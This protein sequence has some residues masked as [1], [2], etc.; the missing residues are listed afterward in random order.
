MFEVLVAMLAVFVAMLAALVLTCVPTA[1]SCEP[2]TASVLFCAIVPA[3]TFW[4]W[5]SLPAE[6]TL[7][8]PFVS[9]VAA[10]VPPLMVYG[11]VDGAAVL[12]PAPSAT[13]LALLAV[14]PLPNAMLLPPVACAALPSAISAPV[15]LPA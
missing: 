13:S 1:Y 4:I 5:R 9:L 3:A 8:T 12:L 6:P 2:F 14:A 15:A 10:I 7:T 11:P